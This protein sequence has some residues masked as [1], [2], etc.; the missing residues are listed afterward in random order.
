[1]KQLTRLPQVK[2]KKE[3][4]NKSLESGSWGLL[5]ILTF[6][7]FY[8][9]TLSCSI[10]QVYIEHLLYFNQARLKRQIG[11]LESMKDRLKQMNSYYK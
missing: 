10:Q 8:C 4:V 3:G 5:Q 2:K 7:D 9:L 11:I 6:S 1:M